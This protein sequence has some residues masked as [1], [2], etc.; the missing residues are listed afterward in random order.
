VLYSSACTCAVPALKR[1]VR[2]YCTFA[3][4]TADYRVSSACC[5]TPHPAALPRAMRYTGNRT[6]HLYRGY[7]KRRC[8]WPKRKEAKSALGIIIPPQNHL[9]NLLTPHGH[10]AESGTTWFLCT[11]SRRYGLTLFVKDPRI[12]FVST[13]AVP[14]QQRPTRLC[15]PIAFYSFSKICAYHI[16][17]ALCL[18]QN[19][20]FILRNACSFIRFSGFRSCDQ[21]PPSP[22][23]LPY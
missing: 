22:L 15:A 23:P 13:L 14:G 2:T 16:L 11:A 9:W 5:T 10:K 7:I 20:F 6:A 4:I 18:Y 17:F 1:A 12:I 21:F 3:C 19:R 8:F